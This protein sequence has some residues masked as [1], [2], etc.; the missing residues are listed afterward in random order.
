VD[1]FIYRCTV[2]F[3]G[4]NF[5]FQLYVSSSFR[6]NTR[7]EVTVS[8]N[9]RVLKMYNAMSSLLRF[10]N[11]NIYFCFEKKLYIVFYNAGVV[12]D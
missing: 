6:K 7:V 9:A 5:Q 11:E 4:V 10:E 8:Y 12:V 1:S 2:S 3:I